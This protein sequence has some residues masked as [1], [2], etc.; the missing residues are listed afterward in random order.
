MAINRSAEAMTFC[1]SSGFISTIH[2]G[3]H[4]WLICLKSIGLNFNDI[5]LFICFTSLWTGLLPDFAMLRDRAIT[6]SKKSLFYTKFW[7]GREQRIA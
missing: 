5:Y 2:M 3:V 4:G 1:Y 6:P 7:S